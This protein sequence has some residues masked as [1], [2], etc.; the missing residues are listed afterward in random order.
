MCIVSTN[1]SSS[2]SIF[3]LQPPNYDKSSQKITE[4]VVVK[5]DCFTQALRNNLVHSIAST[6]VPGAFVVIESNVPVMACDSPFSEVH[7]VGVEVARRQSHCFWSSQLLRIEPGATATVSDSCEIKQN[8]VQRIG[9]VISRLEHPLD[10]LVFDG[11]NREE[12]RYLRSAFG[13]CFEVAILEELRNTSGQYYIRN[14]GA[15]LWEGMLVEIFSGED[16]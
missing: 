6:E 14:Q 9:T 3:E 5:G 4:C 1:N 13:H 8:D 15:E 7:G 16:A 12:Q 10:S 11:L 2:S